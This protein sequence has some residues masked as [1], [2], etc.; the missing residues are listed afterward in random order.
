METTH[1][2]GIVGPSKQLADCL[3]L[4]QQAAA[5]DASIL[6]YGETG[7]GKE[8]FARTIHRHSGRIHGDFVAVDCAALP[9]TII[10]SLLFGHAK[11]SFTDADRAC[12]GLIRQAHCGTLFLD[13]VGELSPTLQKVF[14]R[15]LQEHRFRP[16]GEDAEIESDF[17]LI[18]ATNRELRH[19]V[20][21]GQF[22][23]DLLYRLQGLRIDLPA[24]RSRSE[25]IPALAR[26]HLDLLCQKHGVAEKQLTPEFLRTLTL[27]SWPGNIRELIST[28]EQAL[29]TARREITLFAKHLPQH[30]R[31]QVA[32][33]ALKTRCTSE[34]RQPNCTAAT[35]PSLQD[36]RSGIFSLAE[37]QY[38]ARLVQQTG[39]NVSQACQLAGLSR[40]R[41]YSLL[42]KHQIPLH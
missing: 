5:S 39:Q 28:L 8:L 42:K 11:G 18:A 38:L 21:A 12:A 36:F 19:A 25:D 2:D 30:I 6:L 29:L 27:Y 7:T 31:I 41:Y 33:A 13:E 23:Q 35:L 16:L 37:K 34:A 22:R 26:H 15:V 4:L 3:G 20:A 14:L 24:L 1:F 32:R 10:G 17:R 40:S 9:G